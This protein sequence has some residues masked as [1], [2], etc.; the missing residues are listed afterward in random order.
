LGH[1]RELGADMLVPP[2]KATMPPLP[3]PAMPAA[4]HGLAANAW[5]RPRFA[6][7]A[8]AGCSALQEHRWTRSQRSLVCATLA[9][10]CLLQLGE[11]W[12]N[13]PAPTRGA[14]CARMKQSAQI[15]ERG[16]NATAPPCKRTFYH[17]A[18]NLLGVHVNYQIKLIVAFAVLGIVGIVVAALILGTGLPAATRT[19]FAP[20]ST[21]L[22]SLAFAAL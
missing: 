13:F 10:C 5:S 18:A 22:G 12:H 11:S 19:G 20:A 21:T 7:E 17:A 4:G 2:K 1:P 9:S 15:L 16:G 6:M 8:R 3:S 14:I